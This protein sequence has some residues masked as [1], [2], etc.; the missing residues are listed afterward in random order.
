MKFLKILLMIV[1]SSTFL[2]IHNG[3]YLLVGLSDSRTMDTDVHTSRGK[4]FNAQTY[5]R[6]HRTIAWLCLSLS[7]QGDFFHYSFRVEREICLRKLCLLWRI[8][9]T[10]KPKSTRKRKM[11]KPKTKI[12]RKI[13]CDED[14]GFVGL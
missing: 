3:R 9:N 14:R 7:N 12:C 10:D 13:F 11:Q 5:Y 4:S 6:W 2:D 1:I 8:S